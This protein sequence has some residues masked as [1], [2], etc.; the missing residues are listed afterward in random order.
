MSWE[1]T[2]KVSSVCP[3][4]QGTIEQSSYM[5]D[6]N[7]DKDGSP[8]IKCKYCSTK[9]YAEETDIFGLCYLTPIL[10]PKYIR[11]KGMLKYDTYHNMSDDFVISLEIRN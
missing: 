4:G 3:C 9:Y 5:D 6:W 11:P 10:Y 7:R 2:C 1:E 8:I